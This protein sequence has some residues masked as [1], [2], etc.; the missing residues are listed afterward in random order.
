MLEAPEIETRH[1]HTG[2][3]RIDLIIGVLAIVLSCVSVFIAIGHGR[4]MEKLVAANTWP[5]ID[6][7]TGNNADGEDRVTLDLR[8]TGV[9]PARI[10]T[11]EV[12]YNGN[13]MPDSRALADA[14]CGINKESRKKLG[15]ISYTV[16][17]VRNIVLPARE[18]LS[19]ISVA[20]KQVPAQ[21]WDAA[22]TGRFNVEVK[23]CY[24][25]VFDECWFY[26][27]ALP[28]P[29]RVDQ[30]KPTQKIQFEE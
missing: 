23:L 30:C 17:T 11:F 16:D 7:T 1:A 8:N 10:E 27:S 28:R 19:F 6:Y 15:P 18:K 22:N 21:I 5:N 26:D 25:S 29:S 13:P 9:G 24:C 4:T 2:H 12:F 3:S 20:K 14:C